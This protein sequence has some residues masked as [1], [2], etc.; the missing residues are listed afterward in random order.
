MAVTQVAEH[1]AETE[2]LKAARPARQPGAAWTNQTQVWRSLP[3]VRLLAE[4]WTIPEVKKVGVHVDGV[5]IHLWVIMPEDNTHAESRIT[6]AERTYLNATA[7]HP[8]ELD[9]VPLASVSEEAL[10][11]FDTVLER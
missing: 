5:G 10:P 1:E 11:S 9:V 8:F 7:L 4:I 6:A 2:P 3:M